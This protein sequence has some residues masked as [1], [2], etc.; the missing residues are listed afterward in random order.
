MDPENKSENCTEWSC[1][2]C[3]DRE[4]VDAAGDVDGHARPTRGCV[5][6]DSLETEQRMC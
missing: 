2:Q 6:D 3:V 1:E 5:A 4:S